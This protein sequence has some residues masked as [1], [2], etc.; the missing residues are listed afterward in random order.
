MAKA[1]LLTLNDNNDINLT[2]ELFEH[3]IKLCPQALYR[4]LNRFVNHNDVKRCL[5]GYLLARWAISIET[6]QPLSTITIE[7]DKYGKPQCLT[8][9]SIHF[10]ISHSG[11]FV[12]CAVDDELIGIDVETVR[13]V[14]LS[15]I[16]DCFASNEQEYLLRTNDS[17]DSSEAEH[18][19]TFFEIWTKKESYL[20][21]DGRG[22]TAPPTSFSV[23]D[24]LPDTFFHKV[25][26]EKEGK[27][28]HKYVR[29][30]F[31]CHVCS[32]KQKTPIQT[33]LNLSRLCTLL[34]INPSVL[35]PQYSLIY[36]TKKQI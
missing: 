19:S 17:G 22:L 5:L 32:S 36:H 15:I 3:L 4:R 12:V 25:F 30:S 7:K 33:C 18:N 14:N 11:P 9:P 29:E 26:A 24:T 28:G 34:D 1:Y 2:E 35:R 21:R 6:S 23:L 8:T 16:D 27:S 20:K 31:I 13:Q 10:S